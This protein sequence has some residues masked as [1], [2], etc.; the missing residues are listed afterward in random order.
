V[1]QKPKTAKGPLLSETIRFA[2]IYVQAMAAY[3]AGFNA[4][5]TGNF[6]HAGGANDQLGGK[7]LQKAQKAL[8]KLIA[9]SPADMAGRPVLT[10][11]ELF[12]KAAV[13]AVVSKQVDAWNA[14]ECAYIRLFAQEVSDFLRAPA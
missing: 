7:Q 9:I 3:D 5:A 13:A 14:I 4:D 1:K 12:A 8:L 11:E 2:T 6:A 10:R